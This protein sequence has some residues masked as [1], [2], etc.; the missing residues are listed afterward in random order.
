MNYHKLRDS[1]PNNTLYMKINNR[2]MFIPFEDIPVVNE[3]LR[4]LDE[5]DTKIESLNKHIDTL[6]TAFR[7]MEVVLREKGVYL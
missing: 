7:R 2:M 3:M 6:D 5:K 1:A 4:L